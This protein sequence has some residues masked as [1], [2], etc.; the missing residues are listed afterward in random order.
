MPT[1]D[2]ATAYDLVPV[3]GT[4]RDKDVGLSWVPE[5]RCNKVV[6]SEEILP[7]DVD[8]LVDMVEKSGVFDELWFVTYWS[9]ADARELA[10]QL[11]EAADACEKA[12]ST[13]VIS[14]P[15]P[16]AVS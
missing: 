10:R 3:D 13:P 9:P 15:G 1:E 2:T 14:P 6:L 12:G 8:E 7:G 11:L 4:G 5:A 16:R